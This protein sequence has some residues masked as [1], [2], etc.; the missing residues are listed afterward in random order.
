MNCQHP[1]GC[2][3]DALPR[4]KLCAVHRGYVPLDRVPG[5]IGFNDRLGHFP[6]CVYVNDVTACCT[7][8]DPDRPGYTFRTMTAS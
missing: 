5:S 2:T 3:N 1:Y 8:E 4:M 7:C 6:G